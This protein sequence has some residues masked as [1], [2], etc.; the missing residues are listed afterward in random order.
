MLVQF[1]RSYPLGREFTV[2]GRFLGRDAA[3]ETFILNYERQA[4]ISEAAFRFLNNG[5]MEVS[6][7]P[8]HELPINAPAWLPRDMAGKQPDATAEA[9]AARVASL[10]AQKDAAAQ[11]NATTTV[12]PAP[13]TPAERKRAREAIANA[14]P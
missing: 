12:L 6:V 13:K 1:L 2:P 14:A 3:D 11:A 10:Q 7:V 9:E 8:G 4:E 5:G